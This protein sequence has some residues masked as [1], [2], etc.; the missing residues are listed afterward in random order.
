MLKRWMRFDLFWCMC[1]CN[2]FELS[3]D[4]VL[5][6][7]FYEILFRIGMKNFSTSIFG[8]LFGFKDLFWCSAKKVLDGLFF[9]FCI[10]N[11]HDRDHD[12]DHVNKTH[13]SKEKQR[14]G[15]RSCESR[16]KCGD[17]TKKGDKQKKLNGV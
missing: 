4:I 17:S 5:F 12:H 16:R 11:S 8:F 2:T 3:K 1:A 15:I 7:L 14:H 9:F 13:P 10:V 6:H